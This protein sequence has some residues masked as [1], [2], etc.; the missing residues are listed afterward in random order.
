MIIRLD[1]INNLPY[2]RHNVKALAVG[3]IGRNLKKQVFLFLVCVCFS[4]IFL[5]FALQ[6][7]TQDM[8]SI[9]NFAASVLASL[10]PQYSLAI[11]DTHASHS[12]SRLQSLLSMHPSMCLAQSEVYQVPP[13]TDTTYFRPHIIQPFSSS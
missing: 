12:V 6:L 10:P 2:S 8:Q 3:G 5:P 13:H 7:Y 4:W 9:D 1:L 11:E